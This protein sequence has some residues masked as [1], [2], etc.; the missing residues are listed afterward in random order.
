MRYDQGVHS[1]DAGREPPDRVALPP[2]WCRRHGR[3]LIGAAL[4]AVDLWIASGVP[5]AAA[6]PRFQRAMGL[7][8][9]SCH[10]VV[11]HLNRAGAQFLLR[12][13]RDVEGRDHAIWSAVNPPISV[14]GHAGLAV[15]RTSDERA[16]MRDGLTTRSA[17]ME[18]F[19]LLGAGA[20]T[21]DISL[22]VEGAFARTREPVR[23]YV[24]FLRIGDAATR[25]RASLRV[26]AFVSDAPFLSDAR[27][28]TLRPYLAPVTL[29][30]RGFEVN[31]RANAWS[32]ATGLIESHR[33]GTGTEAEDRIFKH[34]QDTYLTMVYNHSSD[35]LAARM[36]FDR[37]DSSLPTLTWMQHLQATAAGSL[38]IGRLVVQPL[39]LFDRFDD[40]PAAGIHDRHQY[41]GLEALAPIGNARRWW[42][43]TRY[44]HEYRTRTELSPEA[45]HQV[46]L[47][48]LSCEL[49]RYAGLALEWAHWGDNIGGPREDALD[50][51]VRL[52]Y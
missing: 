24:A 44:E 42:L 50:A 47:V 28:T 35:W 25:G 20:L 40:R 32:W 52:G 26:G 15:S 11:P 37:Q 3:R 2:V 31:G 17:P 13:D 9:A 49:T 33:H 4:L 38:P 7:P 23:G 51:C 1:R 6:L 41:F 46:A 36:L 30:A 14:V 43:T 5:P 45:D 18:S 34:L 16:G 8:C 48:N 22:H 39:Y 19:R 12:G 29:D 21:R 10:D 27:R